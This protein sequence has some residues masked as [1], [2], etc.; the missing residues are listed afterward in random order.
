MLTHEVGRRYAGQTF[1]EL[2]LVHK[3]ARTASVKA[4]SE[5]HFVVLAKSD[6][7]EIL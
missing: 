2:A 1:G 4:V 6:Y 3:T 7:N 5:A